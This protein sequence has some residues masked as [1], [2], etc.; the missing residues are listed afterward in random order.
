MSAITF[1]HQYEFIDEFD[2]QVFLQGPDTSAQL[3]SKIITTVDK[4][5]RFL[6]KFTNINAVAQKVEDSGFSYKVQFSKV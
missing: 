6:A 3:R 1:R 4:A 2:E 5:K